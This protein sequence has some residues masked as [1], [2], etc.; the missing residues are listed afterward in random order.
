MEKL[1]SIGVVKRM[2]DNGKETKIEM[3]YYISSLF[4]LNKVKPFYDNISLKRIR[5]RI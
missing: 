2:I 5:K 3:R 4:S 1:N